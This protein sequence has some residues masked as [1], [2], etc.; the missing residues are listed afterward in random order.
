VRPLST[1]GGN[2]GGRARAFIDGTASSLTA[3]ELDPENS[4][5]Y[6]RYTRACAL[7]KAGDLPGT[8]QLL[9]ASC[10]PPSIYQ[11]H[12]RLLF[13]VWRQLNRAD[14]KEGRFESVAARVVQMVR[15]DEEMIEAMVG[16]W[17]KV[18]GKVLSPRHFDGSRNLKV[19]DAKALLAAA[20][21]LSRAD[22]ITEAK[23]LLRRF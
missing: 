21:A 1:S 7:K 13:Q 9:I 17:G 18:Q 3:A 2:S 16:H 4:A 10:E 19:S 11:G 6:D 22:L 8:A 12:Y 23:R 5:A 14:L 15:Y 20:T